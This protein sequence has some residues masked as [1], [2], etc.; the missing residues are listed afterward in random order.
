M[1]G[2]HGDFC[3]ATFDPHRKSDRF[4]AEWSSLVI[5]DIPSVLN[6]EIQRFDVGIIHG[7]KGAASVAS[8]GT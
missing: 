5:I 1:M 4:V 2:F 6:L 8:V 7:A 3:A